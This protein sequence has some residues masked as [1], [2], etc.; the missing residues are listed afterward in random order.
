MVDDSHPTTQNDDWLTELQ[1]IREEAKAEQRE[2]QAAHEAKVAQLKSTVDLLKQVNGLEFLRDIQ[3]NVLNGQGLLEQ[4]DDTGKYDR[5]LA[6]KWDGSIAAPT[7]P[8]EEGQAQH[9][10]LIGVTK[11]Q[12]FVNENLVSPATSQSLQKSLIQLLRSLDKPQQ[13]EAKPPQKAPPSKDTFA[14]L[15]WAIILGLLFII[16]V[17]MALGIIL[18][19][20]TGFM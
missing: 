1:L 16:F 15:K 3:K 11:D 12:L 4:L 17:L 9:G 18:L 20:N 14:Q 7:R 6:L 13:A 8:K 19:M 5:A 2:K 10:I